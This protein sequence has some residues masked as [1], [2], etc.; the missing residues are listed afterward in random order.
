[1]NTAALIIM[2]TIQITVAALAIYFFY[3]VLHTKHKK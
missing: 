2:L 1:M 3:R